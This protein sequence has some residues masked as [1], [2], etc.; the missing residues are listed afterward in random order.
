M[1][2]DIPTISRNRLSRIDQWID[3]DD[4]LISSRRPSYYTRTRGNES[5]DRL[6][7]LLRIACHRRQ[8]RYGEWLEFAGE[9][10]SSIAELEPGWD[11]NGSDPPSADA[12]AGTWNLLNSLYETGLVP[13]PHIYPARSGGIQLE[14]E[15][16]PRY[17]EIEL[18]SGTEATYLYSDQ[19]SSI[20]TEGRLREEESLDDVVALIDR[21]CR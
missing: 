13:K 16:G 4:Y 17:L 19:E 12:I 9:Q 6:A 21:V 15:I 2:A 3:A 8:R 1:I 18:L 7:E 10:L 11:S 20:E 5:A 14:W